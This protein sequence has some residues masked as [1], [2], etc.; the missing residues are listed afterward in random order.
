MG[1][2]G[3]I[4]KI[5]TYPWV[6]EGPSLCVRK[7]IIAIIYKIDHKFWFYVSIGYLIDS[8]EKLSR[9]IWTYPCLFD[10][11]SPNVALVYEQTEHFF[12]LHV[13]KC[14]MPFCSWLFNVADCLA[15]SF[16]SLTSRS[17]PDTRLAFWLACLLLVWYKSAFLPRSSNTSFSL[18]F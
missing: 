11:Y 13:A 12:R 3:K 5:F 14:F 8:T 16:S 17:R 18:E 2:F 10:A 4:P 9:Y 7:T 1:K 6:L 15:I